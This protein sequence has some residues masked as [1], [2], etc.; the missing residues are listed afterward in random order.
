M[1]N[2]IL[3]KYDNE[4]ASYERIMH[5]FNYAQSMQNFIR[6]LDIPLPNKPKILELG[7]GTGITTV[8]LREKFPEAEL[9]GLD[10]SLE[11]MKICQQK[12]P[13]AKLIEGD[14]NQPGSFR[15][16]V[17][18]ER[19]ELEKGTFDLI[20]STGSLSEYGDLEKVL[21]FIRELLT[22]EGKLINIGIRNSFIGYIQSVLYLFKARGLRTFVAEAERAGFEKTIPLP[23]S[24]KHFPTNVF[25]YAVQSEKTSSL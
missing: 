16:F 4:A 6:N 14:F 7:C 25:K 5:W 20:I 17:S 21:P 1:K 23:M 19:V 9:F 11:M 18:A 15:D 10:L 12:V 8:V 3:E 13:S 22:E 24:L 2:K